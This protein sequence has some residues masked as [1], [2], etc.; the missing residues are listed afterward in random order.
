MAVVSA[1]LRR[2]ETGRGEHL[3]VSLWEATAVLN[4]EAWMDYAQNGREPVRR[5]NRDSRMVPHGCF[6]C[7]GEDAWLS[8]ACR[9]D[10]DWQRLARCIDPELAADPRF[11]DLAGRREH[12]D[13]LEARIAAW[14]AEGDRWTLT[15][16]LQAAGIPA[17]PTLST[18]DVVENE[19]LTERG[20]I[21]RLAHP[22]AGVRAHAGI[23][24]LLHHRRSGVARP[25]PCLDADTDRVLA[26]VL[27]LD[28]A[29]I[30]DLRSRRIVGV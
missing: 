29:R 15:H 2:E 30:A 21:E 26:D 7:R 28:P 18:R 25:A 24:W 27:G 11:C 14:T 9:D 1:L 3:D 22:R 12:E 16:T 4:T 8:I 17:F 13:E 10:D 6:R 19:H 20:F 23:P 5:G